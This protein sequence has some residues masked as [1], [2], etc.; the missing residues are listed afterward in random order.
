MSQ[1]ILESPKLKELNLRTWPGRNLSSEIPLCMA[2]SLRGLRWPNL[3]R[4]PSMSYHRPLI[5]PLTR[6]DQVG[7]RNDIPYKVSPTS[8]A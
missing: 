8:R 7:G 4:C 5:Y 3:K 1:H 6:M 2:R